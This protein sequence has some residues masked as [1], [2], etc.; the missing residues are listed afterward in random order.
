MFGQ[1]VQRSSDGGK[2][3][4]NVT[5]P[6]LPPGGRVQNIDASHIRKGSA[7]IAIYRFLREHGVAVATACEFDNIENIKKAVEEAAGVALLPEPTLRREVQSGT[8]V[9]VP[10]GGCALVRPLG[11][12]HRRHHKLSA[13][14]LRFMEMLRHAD[15][16]ASPLP[17]GAD[18][19]AAART[20]TRATEAHRRSRN[21]AARAS[22]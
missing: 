16:S 4:K 6:D 11:I 22:H 18:G 20:T 14:A 12:I 7:Y 15:G 19:S 21:G 9:A 1:V 10:L 2:T 13:T 17:N 5:P 3:W 8:L